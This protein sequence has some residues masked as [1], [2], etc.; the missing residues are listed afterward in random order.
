MLATEMEAAI[1]VRTYLLYNVERDYDD[2]IPGTWTCANLR[3]EV[4]KTIS[5][6]TER[7][8]GSR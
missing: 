5:V 4:D 2:L 6:C 3:K 7:A 1:P 8:T